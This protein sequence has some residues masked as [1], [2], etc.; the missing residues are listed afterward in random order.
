MR[1]I[2]LAVVT[3][4]ATAAIVATSSASSRSEPTTTKATPT[5]SAPPELI[6]QAK[7]ESGL[8]FYGNPPSANFTKLVQKFNE[9]Y[10]WIKVTAY[11]LEDNTIFS[12]YASEAGQGVRTADV[13]IA[14]APALWI[15]AKHQKYAMDYTPPDVAKFYP[16]YAKQFPGI[17]IMSPDPAIIVYNK[18]LLGD[19]VP[20]TLADIASDAGSYSRVTGY[21]VDNT[22]GNT[23]LW[24]YV[25]KKGWGSLEKIG[26]R[27]QPTT[28][29]ASQ[30]QLVAQGGAVAAV[31]TSP[32]AKLRIASDPALKELLGWSYMK[33]LTPLVP[34][35]IAIT[36]K[37]S[38]PASAKLFMYFLFSKRGQQAMCEADFTAYRID[39]K[40]AGGCTGML[41]SVMKAVGEQNTYL[42]PFSQKL[43]TD[44]KPFAARWH[45]IFG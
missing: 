4:V 37:A 6:R 11:D 35:G 7:T 5:P 39:F 23:A 29:V 33:D 31:L 17:Y 16:P 44:R 18:K 21:T 20:T 45:Q 27:L 22:F 25:Q 12:K 38:S 14:S 10:P 13:L 34:R 15:Y 42:V 26:S 41:A 32:T 19:K 30:L 2:A 1:K 40:P 28:G 9:V 3:L 43:V 8:V 36:R 24:G